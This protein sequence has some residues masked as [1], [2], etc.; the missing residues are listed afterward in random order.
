MDEA[1]EEYLSLI[2]SHVT[3]EMKKICPQIIELLRSR[4][5][6]DIFAPSEWNGMLVPPV[7]LIIKGTLPNRMCTRA[8]PVRRELF[9]N[10][11]EGV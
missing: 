9:K 5:A 6:Q 2:D 7:E 8:R 11:Q 4:Q 1:R 3:D 10:G